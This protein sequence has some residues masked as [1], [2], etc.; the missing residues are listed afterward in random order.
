MSET[1]RRLSW[2]EVAA[3]RMARHGLSA[4]LPG[5]PADAAAAMCG[6]H[7]QVMVAAETSVA[8]RL[9]GATRSDVRAALWTDRTLV[10][11]FGPRGTVHLLPAELLPRWVGAMS[12]LPPQPIGLPEPA[13]LTPGQTDEVVAAVD[14]AL[15][16][17]FLT[18]EELGAAVVE[19]IGAWA[20]EPVMPAFGGQ[21][22]RWRQA[23]GTAANRGA[24]CFGPNRGRHVTY[25]S[26]RTWLEGYRPVEGTTA[27]V[28]LTRA[29]LHAYGPATP[30]DLARWLGI[31]P[32][33]AEEM[34]A[35]AGV[36]Q[37]ERAG[38]VAW[39][40]AGDDAE[41]GRPEGVV[42]LPYFDAYVVGAR[43]RELL[44]PG[45]AAGRAL[46]GGQAGNYP[47]VLVDG[48]VAGVW[49]QKPAARRVTVRVELLRPLTPALR[50]ALDEQVARLAAILELDAQL[51]LGTVTVG[52]HA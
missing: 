9:G 29:Y 28:G 45:A 8:L 15:I 46:A 18:L 50:R 24:L 41:A 1:V 49:H 32:G 5:D 36:E 43:P 6:A 38:T 3:R 27:L 35:A 25:T 19:Q 47:V 30:R 11:T 48:V 4:P 31:L 21:W 22:P 16:G 51:V 40:L 12:A 17:A 34:I 39:Q 10:K 44:F 14:R 33:P 13:R 26:P 42:L 23:I 20:G 37:V 52:P 2:D 7:A